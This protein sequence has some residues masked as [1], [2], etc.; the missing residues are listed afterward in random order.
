VGPSGRSS[1][2]APELAGDAEGMECAA[3]GG[4]LRSLRTVRRAVIE[5]HGPQNA[6][7]YPHFLE[8]QGFRTAFIGARELFPRVLRN[9]I[10]HHMAFLS[11]ERR[12][13]FLA[14]KSALRYLAGGGP[15]NPR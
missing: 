7:E 5:V 9:V 13:G 14:A 3:L 2:R 6:E 15:I 4:G 11:Y 8:A 12:T 1:G 10:S